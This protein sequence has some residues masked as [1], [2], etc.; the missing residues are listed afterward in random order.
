M[1]GKRIPRP[2]DVVE[3]TTE[4]KRLWVGPFTE[5]RKPL[6]IVK[7]EWNGGWSFA[8]QYFAW[9]DASNV[10]FV[11]HATEREYIAALEE[12]GD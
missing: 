8:T 6:V 7:A 3:L 1:A 12:S 4:G 2:G 11:R 9:V 10:R 5:K